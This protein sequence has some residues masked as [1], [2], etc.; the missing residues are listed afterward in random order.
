MNCV[1]LS[2]VAARGF[3][4]A[5]LSYIC[6]LPLRQSAKNLAC[7]QL[8]HWQGLSLHPRVMFHFGPGFFQTHSTYGC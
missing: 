3:L 7:E 6:V 1:Q 4:R 5:G 2:R 8:W